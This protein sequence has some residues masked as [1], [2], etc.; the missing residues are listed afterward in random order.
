M[1]DTLKLHSFSTLLKWILR[2]QEQSRSIFGIHEALHHRLDVD[3]PFVGTAFGNRLATPV[4][5]AAGPLRYTDA[6]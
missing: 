3:A 6:V 5:P 2:E 4:G 1:S